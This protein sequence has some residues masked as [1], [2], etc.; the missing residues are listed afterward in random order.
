MRAGVEVGGWPDDVVGPSGGRDFVWDG[1]EVEDE[2]GGFWA[3]KELSIGDIEGLVE[4]WKRA[5]ERAVKAGVDVIEI[6]GAVSLS[7]F[8][9]F[10]RSPLTWLLY[11]YC[12]ATG[13]NDFLWINSTVISSINFSAPS[14][15]IGQM[16]TVALSADGSNWS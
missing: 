15:T 12:V 16:H 7:P 2:E 14:P 11:F 8:S 3:P 10:S 5:S 9:D 4:D 6:H 1:K 13:T